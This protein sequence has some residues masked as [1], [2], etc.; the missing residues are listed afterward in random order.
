MIMLTVGGLGMT[1]FTLGFSDSKMRQFSLFPPICKRALSVKMI[2]KLNSLTSKRAESSPTFRELPYISD[3]FPTHH[4]S[5]TRYTRISE[6]RQHFPKKTAVLACD[7]DELRR[8]DPRVSE[9]TVEV[10]RLLQEHKRKM[11]L[12]HFKFCNIGT[13]MSK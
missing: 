2:L 4:Q 6:T 1:E 10:N 11:W 7:R 12:D 3:V 5:C 13:D 8:S 9:L